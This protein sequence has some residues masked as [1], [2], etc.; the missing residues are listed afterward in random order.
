MT[1]DRWLSSVSTL[2]KE[3]NCIKSP[4]PAPS[5]TNVLVLENRTG[6]FKVGIRLT[7]SKVNLYEAKRQNGNFTQLLYA[8]SL[9]LFPCFRLSQDYV[10]TVTE[11]LLEF[12][13]DGA[14]AIEVWGHRCAGN[15]SS[16]WEVDSLHAKTRTL[17]DR[18]V[19]GWA[20]CRVKAGTNTEAKSRGPQA[21]VLLCEMG[22]I[23]GTSSH[24][25]HSMWGKANPFEKQD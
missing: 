10:V 18:F 22:T 23:K 25:R 4:L 3:R 7:T 11:E 16:I 6:G 14:L 17:H 24:W 12:L 2:P 1:W 13:S 9:S 19:L 5:R 8:W 21:C 20:G 15:G